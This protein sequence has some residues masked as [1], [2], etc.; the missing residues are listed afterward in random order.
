MVTALAVA[1]L[2]AAPTARAMDAPIAPDAAW[3]WFQDPRAVYDHGRTFTGYVTA[4][5]DIG[6]ASYDH[7]SNEL[8]RSVIAR[9]FQRD[10]HAAPALQ[11]LSD[12]RV[13]AI[14]SAH[15][16]RQ[17]YVRVTKRPGDVFGW[18]DT[19]VIGSNAPGFDTY[20]YANPVRVGRSIYVFWRAE[21]G[22]SA[23]GQAAYSVSD[24][25]S[26]T[27]APGRVLLYNAGQRPYVKY[28]ARG[29][30][31]HVAYTEGHPNATQT[32]IR[33]AAFRDGRLY[34]ADG[35]LIGDAPVSA[36]RGE[37]V[38]GGS[39]RAWVWDVASD[40]EGRPVI[41]YATFPSRA[42]HRYRYARWNGTRWIDVE[43]T[44]AGG[45]IDESGREA[46]YSGGMSLD[47]GDPSTV[48]LS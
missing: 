28:D 11:V 27:W 31:I 15:S 44:R 47:H 9:G 24:D 18:T 45:S 5:G 35:S 12:G 34:R 17:M 20:T 41:V 4:A 25:G 14:W 43:L 48:Y 38:Y 30:T 6:V 19:R 2:A 33:Y 10:D 13:M 21:A 8:R 36:A 29:D 39:A 7:G 1:L 26:E 37:R 16:G 42:D 23:A 46:Q 40:S 32:G 22:S 3:C